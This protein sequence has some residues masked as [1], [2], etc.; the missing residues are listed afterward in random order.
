MNTPEL[1]IRRGRRQDFAAVMRLLVPNSGTAADRR[2]VRR[3]RHIA[4]DLGA[5]LYVATLGGKV[6][7]VIHVSYSRQL[8]GGQ[9]ARVEDLAADDEYARHEIRRRLLEFALGRARGR[10]CAWLC[11]VPSGGAAGLAV[12]SAG[13]SRQATEYCRP[14]AGEA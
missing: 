11:C 1:E 5:D 3:F 2:T 9:R 6:V 14:L 12:E 7:G 4:A 10:E 13:L 8:T